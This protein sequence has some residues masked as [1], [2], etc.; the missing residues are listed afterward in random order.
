MVVENGKGFQTALGVALEA[1]CEVERERQVAE[2]LELFTDPLEGLPKVVG[3][4]PGAE[5]GNAVERR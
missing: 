4:Q 5:P 2:Q 3:E 1:W